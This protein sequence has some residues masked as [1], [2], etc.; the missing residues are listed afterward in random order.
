MKLHCLLPLALAFSLRA[1]AQDPGLPIEFRVTSAFPK[2]VTADLEFR[3]PTGVKWPT[4]LYGKPANESGKIV[5]DA[6]KPTAVFAL[7][8]D[9]VAQDKGDQSRRVLG[10]LPQPLTA[11]LTITGIGPLAVMEKGKNGKPGQVAELTGTLEIGGK[12]I[13][14]KATTS[15]SHHDGK[16]DEKNQ[17]LMLNGQMALK[18][19]DV[20]I[21]SLLSIEV[22][23]GLTAF[24]A[25]AATNQK[26]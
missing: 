5:L 26:K 4:F 6:A 14:V 16:G 13:P 20:G 19:S 15:L 3:D 23:F 8:C 7:L 24:P 11:T 2:Y 12:K 22:R 10:S 25:E 17:A 9:K 18:G 21:P 1:F